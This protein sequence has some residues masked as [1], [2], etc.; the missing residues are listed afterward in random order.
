[1]KV[2][3]YVDSSYPTPAPFVRMFVVLR[4][5]QVEAALSM[6]VDTGASN[7]LIL[8]KDI[9]RLGI[10]SSRLAG[11]EKEFMGIGGTI[12]SRKTRAVVE[13]ATEYGEAVKEEIQMFI[14][15]S[16]C[17]HP[18]LMLLPSVLG[19]DVLNRYDLTYRPRVDEVYMEK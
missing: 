14:A 15:S 9:G 11:V 7:T 19:R 17:P 10:D 2:R 5:L 1:M 4:E 13:F 18:R 3:G 16:P 8:W 12:T 6:I